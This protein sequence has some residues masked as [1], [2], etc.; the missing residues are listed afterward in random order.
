MGGYIVW[1]LTIPPQLDKADFGDNGRLG[2]SGSDFRDLDFLSPRIDPVTGLYEAVGTAHSLEEYRRWALRY[3]VADD[4]GK[5]MDKPTK[6]AARLFYD[7][8]VVR[9]HPRPTEVSPTQT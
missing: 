4:G 9:H 8:K 5:R 3:H 2:P 6:M 7:V 1:M